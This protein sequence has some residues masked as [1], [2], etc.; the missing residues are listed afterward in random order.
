VPTRQEQEQ[1]LKSNMTTNEIEK[2]L[3][4]KADKYISEKASEIIKVLDSITE[5]LSY[6]PSF[7]DY[8]KDRDS[9]TQ[10]GNWNYCT[11]YAL[12]SKF[13]EELV[14]NFKDKLIKQYTKELLSKIDLL[15]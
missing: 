13:R 12:E 5:G 3:A 11:K 7:Y 2:Q 1:N 14:H 6:E 8:M 4:N 9:V 10:E 15:G